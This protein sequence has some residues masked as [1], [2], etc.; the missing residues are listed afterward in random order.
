MDTKH[1][2]SERIAAPAAAGI[3]ERFADNQEYLGCAVV[4]I[5]SLYEPEKAPTKWTLSNEKISNYDHLT[6]LGF[7]PLM[8]DAMLHARVH[9]NWL[10]CTPK[11]TRR[12]THYFANKLVY[13]GI[14]SYYEPKE[15]ISP[16]DVEML[17]GPVPVLKSVADRILRGIDAAVD[18]DIEAASFIVTHATKYPPPHPPTRGGILHTC[19]TSKL[20]VSPATHSAHA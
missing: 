15:I 13:E 2:K 5:A 1:I 17:D 9:K 4:G 3:G 16:H 8:V 19:L 18:A 11:E 10:L 20:L 12:Q 7:S 14:G 6:G